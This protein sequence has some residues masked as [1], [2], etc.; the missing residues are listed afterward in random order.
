RGALRVVTAVEPSEGVPSDSDEYGPLIQEEV[1]RLP[2][3]YRAVVALCYWQGLT[4][5]QAAVQLGCPL[6]TVRSRLARARSKLH[7]RLT[8]RGLA[9][10]AGVMAAALG[11]DRKSVRSG[12]R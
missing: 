11:S 5:E 6:G 2:E 12:K 10:L 9:P 4:Q 7:T 1:R 8:H 3:K